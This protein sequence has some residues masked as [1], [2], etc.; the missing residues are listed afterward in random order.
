M[1][2]CLHEFLDCVTC[3]YMCGHPCGLWALASQPPA[4]TGGSAPSPKPQEASSSTSVVWARHVSEFSAPL[5]L[6]GPTQSLASLR[7]EESR[8]N[9]FS[10]HR[11]PRGPG[12]RSHSSL[13]PP[14]SWNWSQTSGHWDTHSLVHKVTHERQFLTVFPAS[15]TQTPRRHT[16]Q[17]PSYTR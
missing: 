14:P 6:S 12:Q 9:S 7:V 8:H 13:P 5:L 4:L 16:P 2:I 3:L 17:K 1:F 11:L 15:E 10:P